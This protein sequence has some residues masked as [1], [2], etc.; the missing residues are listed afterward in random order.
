MATI[1]E[2]KDLA[3]FR[4]KLHTV[5]IDRL[6]KVYGKDKWKYTFIQNVNQ[7]Y[8]VT[9]QYKQLEIFEDGGTRN[10]SILNLMLLE[11]LDNDKKF[12]VILRKERKNIRVELKRE[13]A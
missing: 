1:S 8:S 7:K 5:L 9:L 6:K 12:D 3:Y 13:G 4:L 11:I 2:N 10:E